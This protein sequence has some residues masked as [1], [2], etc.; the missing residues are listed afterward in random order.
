M[1]NNVMTTLKSTKDQ[2]SGLNVRI[3][4]MVAL[5][6]LGFGQ[7]A[8]A[9]WTTSGND[10]YNSNSGNVG[11]G[12]TTPSQKLEVNGA[13]S[14]IGSI[15]AYLTYDR[16]TSGYGGFYRTGGVNRLWDNTFGDVLSFDS[17]GKVGIGTNSPAAKLHVVRPAS[18][19]V[20]VS[21]RA[22][23]GQDVYNQMCIEGAFCTY[24]GLEAAT[25]NTVFGNDLTSI[26]ISPGGNVGIGT[27]TPSSKLHV[28]GDVTVDGNI[29]AKYQD[30]AEWVPAPRPIAPGTVV[31]LDPDGRNTVIPSSE[32]YDTRVA[33]VV[34]AEPG[35]V[36]G[37]LGEGKVKVATTGRVKVRVDATKAPIR[38]GDLLVTSDRQGVAMRSEP[39]DLG[40]RKIHQPGTLIGKALEPLSEGQGE[41]LVLLSLQ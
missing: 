41:I 2:P 22:P 34:S 16:S 8:D 19:A 20:A 4:L 35:I 21:S 17:T 15:A 11:I 14:S 3:L 13:V 33:G 31:T 30:I 26:V 24:W 6:V 1:R 18:N 5:A 7:A 40:G 39:L 38:T 27:D 10:I 29:S 32:S 36:L 28:A 12:V 25:N 37:E 23:S 9:Q